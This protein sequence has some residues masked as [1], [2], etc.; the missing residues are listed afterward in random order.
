MLA[1]KGIV[2]CQM[3]SCLAATEMVHKFQ[4]Y[5]VFRGIKKLDPNI[6][7]MHAAN[8]CSARLSKWSRGSIAWK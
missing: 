5:G 8:D 1:V 7:K 6:S 4:V 2:A 3:A